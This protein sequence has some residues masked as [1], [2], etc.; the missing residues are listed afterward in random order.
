[1]K[2]RSGDAV[3]RLRARGRDVLDRI[4][5]KFSEQRV[6]AEATQ[7][8]SAR[9]DRAWEGNSHWRDGIPDQ[10]EQVGRD[11]FAL[12]GKLARVLDR[13]PTIG[14][15]VEWGSGGGA[16]AVAFAPHAD[17]FIAVDVVQASL[18]ECESR[19][20]AVCETPFLPVLID[21]AA[22]EEAIERIGPGSCDLFLCLYVIE[23]LP[24][25]EYARRIL[26]IAAELLGPSGVMFV[27]IKYRDNADRAPHKRNYARNLASQTIFPIDAFWQV[28]VAH[29]FEPEVVSLVPQNDL[30][31]NYAYVLL[32][33]SKQDRG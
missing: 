13:E 5:P 33:P 3:R 10:W 20:R 21:V 14:T 11:H 29:G 12:F 18:D 4:G 31:H 24:S 22:P 8:W 16:N 27:Q 30:D 1:V 19:T 32:T 23:L 7:Y 25:Q 28:A 26:D 17:R 15:V 6:I 9:A 2:D